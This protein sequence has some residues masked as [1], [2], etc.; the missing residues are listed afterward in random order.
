MAT[1]T[2]SGA[3]SKLITYA[4][5]TADG[6]AIVVY[7]PIASIGPFYKAKTDRISIQVDGHMDEYVFDSEAQ[8]DTAIAAMLTYF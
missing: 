7:M 5:T 2:L 6:S 8:R 3:S 1:I 4:G